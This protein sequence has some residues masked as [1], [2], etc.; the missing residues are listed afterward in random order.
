[1]HESTAR[2]QL[3]L[4]PAKESTMSSLGSENRRTSSRMSDSGFCAD[5]HALLA[6]VVTAV[7][8]DVVLEK[9][10]PRRAQ[11]RRATTPDGRRRSSGYVHADNR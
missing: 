7:E 11:S 3:E 2:L 5:M 6:T 10:V 1:M 8:S 9:A 4:E